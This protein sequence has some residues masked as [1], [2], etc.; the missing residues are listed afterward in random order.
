MR[1]CSRSLGEIAYSSPTWAERASSG[2]GCS[3]NRRNKSVARSRS[4][5]PAGYADVSKPITSPPTPGTT[6]TF[7]VDTACGICV[8]E[9]AHHEPDDH[10]VDTRLEDRHPHRRTEQEV[11]ETLP[12]A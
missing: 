1:C 3:R 7:E 12:D 2:V 11:H 10:R 4:T 5:R 8:R 9:Q 6:P